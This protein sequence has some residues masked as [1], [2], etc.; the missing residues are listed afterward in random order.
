MS[1]MTPNTHALPVWHAGP[2]H[3]I[4]YPPWWHPLSHAPEVELQGSSSMQ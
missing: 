4:L 3:G 2:D 1:Y